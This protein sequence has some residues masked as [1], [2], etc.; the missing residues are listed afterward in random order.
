MPAIKRY[1]DPKQR[2]WFGYLTKENCGEIANR[3]H[4]MLLDRK[5]TF[6]AENAGMMNIEVRTSQA[7][8]YGLEKN[9]GKVQC[10]VYD[11]S[12]KDDMGLYGFTFSDT[13]GGWGL[14]TMHEDEQQAGKDAELGKKNMVY[15]HFYSDTVIRITQYNGYGDMLRWVVAL[16]EKCEDD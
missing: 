4:Q 1:N 13:Y 5:Y 3:I 6:V 14:H 15:I 11:G 9:G 8:R 16:E 7:L 2:G 12:D 10:K